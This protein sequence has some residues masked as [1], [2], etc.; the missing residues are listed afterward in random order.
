MNSKSVFPALMIIVLLAL[1]VPNI[2]NMVR[3][4]AEK[5]SMFD[6]AYSM[7]QATQISDET[8]KPML[9]L[10]TADW[11]P[12]CQS[13]KRSTL[14][15]ATVIDWVTSNTVPVY[16]EADENPDDI[17]TLPVRSYP[18]TLLIQDGEI[19][20]SFGPMNATKY[21]EKLSSALAQSR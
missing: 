7:T 5:P 18:T 16:L 11:C 4:P 8:G 3:G 6:N 9:V 19:L 2:L 15:D 13:L 10:V 21:V 12:P 14:V 17:R 1:V 20:T